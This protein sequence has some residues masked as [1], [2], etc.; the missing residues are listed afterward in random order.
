MKGWTD[1]HPR[2]LQYSLVKEITNNFADELGRG[3]LVKGTP[4][5]Q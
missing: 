2:K 4:K 1:D 5:G 3:S